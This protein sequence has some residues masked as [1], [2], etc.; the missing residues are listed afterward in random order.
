MADR[1][2]NQPGKS[3]SRAYLLW[4]AFGILGLHRLYLGDII[5]GFAFPAALYASLTAT[6]DEVSLALACVLVFWLVR[7]A[8][9]IPFLCR[10]RRLP[11]DDP[12]RRFW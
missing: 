3:V 1:A 6:I 12:R 9:M 7:D 5:R 8:V 4:F 11:R 10:P 2:R